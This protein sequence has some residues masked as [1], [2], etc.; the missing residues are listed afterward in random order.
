MGQEDASWHSPASLSGTRSPSEHARRTQGLQGAVVSSILTATSGWT[1]SM[2]SYRPQNVAAP[3]AP[4]HPPW[5][6]RAGPHAYHLIGTRLPGAMFLV[7]PF[8][9]TEPMSPSSSAAGEVKDTGAAG[10][11]TRHAAGRAQPV[12]PPCHHVQPQHRSWE[13]WGMQRGGVGQAGRKAG[14]GCTG[15]EVLQTLAP[16]DR[17]VAGGGPRNPQQTSCTAGPRHRP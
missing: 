16:L 3:R 2:G 6:G 9:G 4:L 10:G 17:G 5:A 1:R 14:W 12:S 7:P 8:P 11:D 13:S 15:H